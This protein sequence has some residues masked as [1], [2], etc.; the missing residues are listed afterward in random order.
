MNKHLWVAIY[1]NNLAIEVVSDARHVPRAVLSGQKQRDRILMCNPAAGLRGIRPGLSI[2]AALALAP[3]LEIMARNPEK[4]AQALRELAGW[5]IRFTPAVSVEPPNALLLDI[6]AS[7]KFFGGLVC[8]QAQLTRELGA[9][10]YQA[11]IACAPTALASLWL[12]RT[13]P[14]ATIRKLT[15]LPGR[16]AALSVDCLRW[17]AGILK[18]LREMGIQTLGESIRLPRDGL[19]RRIGPEKVL[20]LDRGFGRQPETREFYR[21]PRLF[22]AA[23]ELP[24]ETS[25]CRLLLESLKI[26]LARLRAFLMMNQGSIRVLW[27]HLH[28]DREPVTLMR[29]GLLRPVMDTT[30]LQDLAQIHFDAHRFSAP[31]V[32]IELQTDLA[33]IY[34]AERTDLFGG[35]PDQASGALELVEQLQGRLGSRAVYGIRRVPEHRPESAWKTVIPSGKDSDGPDVAFEATGHRP[36][37][38]LAEPVVLKTA[39]DR[40][41]FQDILDLEGGPERIET[42]W[43]DGRDIRRDYF[44]ARNRNGMRLWVFRD[45]RGSGWYLHG[46]FG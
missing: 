15:E 18:M 40:P 13:G 5:A 25:D 45:C 21:P 6:H 41:V 24:I 32:S 44:I 23:L 37:W 35:S 1:F 19:A 28:Y 42:G 43:W 22:H 3:E 17:P 10:R 14:E 38:M 36:L 20:E 34:P 11:N 12:A 16:L 46:L 2:N 26:L 8:L 7:L 33:G 29:I 31:V 39:E 30:Y 9:Q 4:E 27:L